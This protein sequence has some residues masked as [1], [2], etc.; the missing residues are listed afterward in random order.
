MQAIPATTFT[1]CVSGRGI[2][3]Y[4]AGPSADFLVSSAGIAC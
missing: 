4:G 1:Q 2:G 3:L